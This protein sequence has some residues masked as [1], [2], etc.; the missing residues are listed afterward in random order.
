MLTKF[1]LPMISRLVV[2]PGISKPKLKCKTPKHFSNDKRIADLRTPLP[3]T[4]ILTPIQIRPPKTPK[5]IKRFEIN[6][7]LKH[8]ELKKLFSKL[9]LDE[10]G[11]LSFDLV[12][13]IFCKNLNQAQLSY[14]KQVI[15]SN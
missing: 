12:E 5:L 15:L 7:D 13:N 8:K 10:D 6:D 9:D 3:S 2:K 1:E 11:H 4:R 14:I